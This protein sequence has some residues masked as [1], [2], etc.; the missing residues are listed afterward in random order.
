MYGNYISSLAQTRGKEFWT[1]YKTILNT[2]HEE[3]G[4]IRSKKGR[5][6]YTPEEI[7]KKIETTFSGG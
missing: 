1:S 2:K 4:I 6:L 5:L 3:V 7:C